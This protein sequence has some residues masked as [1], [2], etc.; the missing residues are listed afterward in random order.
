MS[1][2]EGSASQFL[3]S[4]AAH[5]GQGHQARGSADPA[6]RATRRPRLRRELR[7]ARRRSRA[8]RPRV[9][10]RGADRR[11]LRGRREQTSA[12]AAPDGVARAPRA[13][14]PRSSRRSASSSSTRRSGRS[15]GTLPWYVLDLR[16]PARCAGCCSTERRASSRPRRSNGRDA[17]HVV[18][19]D[20]GDLR[21]PL[22]V[23]ALG[24]RRVLGGGASDPAARGAPLA[25]PGGP[26]ARA[27]R[28]PR[29]VARP[30]LR[31][32]RLLLVVPRRTASCAS[33]SARSTRATTSSEPTSSARRRRR[34]SRPSASRATGSRTSSATRPTTASSSSATAPA[35]A[36]RRPPRASA[37]RSTSRSRCGR[38]LR[39]V[40]DGEQHARAGA[41]AL[42][43]VLRRAPLEVRRAP[44]HAGRR[45]QAQ[46][47]PARDA[48]RA[49]RAVAA[50]PAHVDVP[51]LPRHLP[52]R[53]GCRAAA[54]RGGYGRAVSAAAA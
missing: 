30:A 27:R 52:A 38:E 35:T 44:A 6:G 41:G 22:V 7:R 20:R 42:R 50:E 23:D 26:P 1:G 37:P 21:A 13:R 11:P 2:R 46:P 24:W 48:P 10:R 54:E 15:A 39:A 3:L 31:P 40:L 25:R 32:R 29:A 34:A 14:R 43:R 51:P 49:H 18:H 53:G 45:R 5:A 17:A 9:R 28:R 4:C 33:A 19:T 12:C 47:A 8:R 36:S 16:L